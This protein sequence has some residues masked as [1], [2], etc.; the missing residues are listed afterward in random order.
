MVLLI[1]IICLMVLGDKKT[2]KYNIFTLVSLNFW[3][4]ARV[5]YLNIK[6]LC[7]NISIH[8]RTHK[9]I[10]NIGCKYYHDGLCNMLNV[11]KNQ[12]I[13]SV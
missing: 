1:K 7:R 3:W 9:T 12:R 6:I 11:H 10:F 2:Y 13:Y 8:S 4:F 5:V